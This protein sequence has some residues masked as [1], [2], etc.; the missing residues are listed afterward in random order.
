[1]DSGD[2]GLTGLNAELTADLELEIDPEPV[3]DLCMVDSTTAME[4][5]V[6]IR[7]VNHQDHAQVCLNY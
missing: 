7:N 1:M 2:L 6:K 4:L 3:R 5:T